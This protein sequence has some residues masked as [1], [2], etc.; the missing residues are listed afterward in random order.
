MTTTT[1]PKQRMSYMKAG[2]ELFYRV[3]F[4]IGEWFEYEVADFFK[5]PAIRFWQDR[6]KHCGIEGGYGHR[7]GCPNANR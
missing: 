7:K 3:L 6:C 1:S 5:M 2:R 4:R